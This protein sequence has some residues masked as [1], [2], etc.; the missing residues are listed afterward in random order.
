MRKSCDLLKH[1]N[2]KRDLT[3][4]RKSKLGMCSPG[5]NFGDMLVG[6]RDGDGRFMMGFLLQAWF[7]TFGELKSRNFEHR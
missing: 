6:R 1:L 3:G 7:C 2:R 4:K 5:I